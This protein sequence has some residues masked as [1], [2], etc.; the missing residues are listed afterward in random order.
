M[1]YH[2][3]L[4]PLNGSGRDEIALSSA[5][6]VAGGS[7]AHVV[8]QFVRPDIRYVAPVAG[9]SL[10][11]G[12]I[13]DISRSA[14]QIADEAARAAHRH[15]TTAAI[16]AKA[17]IADRPRRGGEVTASFREAEGFVF[18]CVARAAKFADLVVYGPLSGPEDFQMSA[19]FT[20]ALMTAK[21]PVLISPK[22]L[23]APFRKIAIGWDGGHAT[24]RAVCAAVPLL[25][26]A[27]S[28]EVITVQRTSHTQT[29][30]FSEIRDYLALSQ[31]HAARRIVDR[32][33]RSIGEELV[34]AATAADADLL[35]MG[36]YG[37]SP[38]REAIFGGT[39]AY[40]I[41]EPSIPIFLAH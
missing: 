14:K 32:G 19:G 28:I 20:E 7:K 10:V 8:A 26:A 3:I 15:F 41:D 6:A 23:T 13:E 1:A 5:F 38:L 36:G 18:E 31:I 17:S 12:L 25:A 2:Q 21:R 37:H 27:D 11:P 24:A 22:K 33:T 9:L 4:V 39:T 34:E 29:D 40:A 30:D 16:D 35:V